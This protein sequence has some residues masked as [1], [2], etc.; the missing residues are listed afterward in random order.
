MFSRWLAGLSSLFAVVLIAAGGASAQTITWDFATL[1]GVGAGECSNLGAAA[2][3]VSQTG[4]G[5]IRLTGAPL[6]TVKDDGVGDVERGLGLAQTAAAAC[7]PQDEVGDGGAGTLVMNF[8][9]VEPPGTT[10]TSVQLGSLQAGEC[11]RYS[12]STDGGT[13]FG[14]A[15]EVCPLTEVVTVNIGLLTDGLVLKFEKA[16]TG[17]GDNDYVVTS[18]TTNSPTGCTLTQGFWKNH[19]NAWPVDTLTIGGIVYTKAELIAIMKAE[20]KGNGI[21]SLVQQLIAAKLNVLSGADP[22]SI[23][24]AIA[25]ADTLIDSAG[26]KIVIG[27]PSSPFLHP[28]VTSAL[29]TALTNFNQGTTGP[30]KCTG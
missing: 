18:V 19:P 26:G 24:A 11:Y 22:S 1:L 13:N 15:I 2:V 12:I 10:L 25:A 28:S 3:D 27:P 14:A 6:L 21:M 9:N 7:V 17:T 8:D 16:L 29:N 30:G 20:T 23:S 4:L 5:F